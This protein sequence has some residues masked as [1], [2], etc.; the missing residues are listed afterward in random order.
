MTGRSAPAAPLEDGPLG[1]LT[2]P[3]QPQERK[4]GRALGEHDVSTAESLQDL[5][6]AGSSTRRRAACVW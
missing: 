3:P 4:Q 2:D 5:P 6:E 1:L